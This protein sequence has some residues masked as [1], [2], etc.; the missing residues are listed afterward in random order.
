MLY[1]KPA[2]SKGSMFSVVIALIC[3]AI[4]A[5]VTIAIKSLP[6]S[7]P[8]SVF[9]FVR[10]ALVVLC[11]LPFFIIRK[12]YENMTPS[13]IPGIMALGFL[14]VLVFN[15]LFFLALSY[16]PA[17]S[18]ASIGAVNPLF[19][20]FIAVLFSQ[21]TP[22]RMQLL[23]FMLAFIGATLIVTHGNMGYMIFAQSTGELYT[24]AA[25]ACQALYAIVLRKVSIHYSPLYVTFGTAFCG[26][27]FVAPFVANNEFIE[28][29]ASFSFNSWLLLAFISFM[30]STL[31]IF[32]YAYAMRDLGPA[33][34]GRIVF[35]SMPICTVFLAR[36]I[37]HEPLTIWQLI[38]GLLIAT[39][40][41]LGL[42]QPE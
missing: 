26:T 34:S 39:S 20:M 12:E 21:C 10:Y 8:T 16:A 24:L 31:A 41:W 32:M 4:W 27:L 7:M 36:F 23:A 33:R 42:R 35:T 3:S 2:I 9:A 28:I 38:G 18:V 37:L 22:S 6:E 25:V 19:L 1:F 40:L 5:G 29:L 14:L 11:L 17:I 13:D 30:G 15:S